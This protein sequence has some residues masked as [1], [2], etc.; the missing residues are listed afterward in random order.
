VTRVVVRRTLVV[1]GRRRRPT[2]EER[3]VARLL[4]QG[5]LHEDFLCVDCG[6]EHLDP[7][8]CTCWDR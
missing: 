3:E 1:I 6:R 4:A 2:L 8:L 5:A 7:T